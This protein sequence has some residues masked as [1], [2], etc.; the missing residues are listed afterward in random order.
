MAKFSL[1]SALLAAAVGVAAIATVPANAAIFVGV[2]LNG[3]AITTVASS[4]S[5][6][7]VFSSTVGSYTYSV[8]A[9]GYPTLSQPQLQT[10]SIDVYGGNASD[11]ITLYVTQTDLNP[12]NGSLLSK[13]TYNPGSPSSPA[14]TSVLSTY[15]D[16]GN[17]LYGG[18]LLSSASFADG[19]LQTAQDVQAV[20]TANLFSETTKY[21]IKL[22]NGAS[23]NDTINLSAAAVPEPA[24]WAMMVGGFGLL[25]SAL[26]RKRSNVAVNFG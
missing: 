6:Q 25:G 1:K 14:D 3:G 19:T 15:V 9:T 4:V 23:V 20:S 16:A 10:N 7:V 24:S 13:F 2:S 5:G 18:T 22:S 11:V 17:N 26:R 8:S 12:I 21:V